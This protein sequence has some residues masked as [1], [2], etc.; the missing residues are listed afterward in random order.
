[1]GPHIRKTLTSFQHRT[2]TLRGEISPPIRVL[3][4]IRFSTAAKTLVFDNIFK[5]SGF[6]VTFLTG[7]LLFG[8]KDS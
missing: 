7:S 5:I 2:F 6:A 8:N 1:M 4:T 3:L